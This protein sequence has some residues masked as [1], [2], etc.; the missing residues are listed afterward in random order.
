MQPLTIVLL[1]IMLVLIAAI[2]AMYF[3]GKKLQ[4]RQEESEAQVEANKQTISMLIIDKKKLPL[5]QSGLP[6]AVIDS[7]PFLYRRSKV[8]VVKAKVGP[9]ITTLIADDKIFDQIPVKANVKAEV[10]GIY[11]TGV[12]GLHGAKVVTEQKKKGFFARAV[13]KLQ[14]VGGAKSVK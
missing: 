14:E 12:K 4:K 1:V 8:P 2:I 13:D 10:S 7:A 3:Y 11:I 6:Q 5:K 9:Q